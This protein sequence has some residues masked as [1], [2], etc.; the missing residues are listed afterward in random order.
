MKKLLALLLCALAM[1]ALTACGPKVPA[2][3]PKTVPCYVTVVNGAQPIEGAQIILYSA[4][5]GGSLTVCGTTNSTGRADISTIL[6]SYVAKGAPEGEYIVTIHKE[7]AVEHTK[8]PEELEKMSPPEAEKYEREMQKKRDAM[9]RIVPKEYTAKE[10]SDLKTTISAANAGK[11]L[12]KV[13]V[14]PKLKK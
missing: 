9:P 7:A 14:G 10:T 6:A 13:D 3:M 12:L 5:E 1:T 8:S 11:E 4:G 2:G